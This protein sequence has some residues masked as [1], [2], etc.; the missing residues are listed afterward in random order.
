MTAIAL[1]GEQI[2][3]RR[4]VGWRLVWMVG[5]DAWVLRRN[6]GQFA[7]RVLV[8][9]TLFV[10]VFTVVFPR[11][12]QGIGGAR[13]SAVFS[14]LLVPGTMGSVAI[15]QGLQAVAIP[16]IGD[17]GWT[18]QIEDRALSPVPRQVLTLAKILGGA[19]EGVVGAA[20]V[21]PAVLLLPTHPAHLAVRPLPTALL[22]L[23]A[24][25]LGAT[26]GLMLGSFLKPQNIPLLFTLFVIPMTFL[27]ATY[28]PWASLGSLRW[29][30]II[31]L[32]NP[33]LYVNEALRAVLAPQL[34]H[35]ALAGSVAGVV[36]AIVAFYVV[37]TRLFWRR[38]MFE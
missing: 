32:A 29:L 20:F 26:M 38:V 34:P 3:R 17:L 35:M 12:G 14:T 9:P 30:Q 2:T 33:L 4:G 6:V 11:V 37:G 19:V 8:Q 10:F 36:V 13:G 28:Y 24:A 25:G 31:M 21:I 18:R 15:L 5:R 7:L 22:V 1:G 27:G 23:G 16:L